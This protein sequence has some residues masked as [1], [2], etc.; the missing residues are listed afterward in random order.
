MTLFGLEC[1]VVV[2]AESEVATFPLERRQVPAVFTLGTTRSFQVEPDS[3]SNARTKLGN[4]LAKLADV[5]RTGVSAFGLTL[6]W[7]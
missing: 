1:N 4:G 2:R 3:E 7:S 6:G 5:L